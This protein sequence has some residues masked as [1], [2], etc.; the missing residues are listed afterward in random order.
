[1]RSPALIY[2]LLVAFAVP[3][4]S[5][6]KNAPGLQLPIKRAKGVIV[7]DGKIDEPDWQE[8]TAA[9]DFFLNYPVDTAAAPFQTEARLTFDE[10]ALYVSFVCYDD[11]TPDIVQ[12]LRRDF[13]F[14]S[15][16]NIGIYLG[17]YNDGINGFF[18]QTTPFGVQTEGIISAAGADDNSYNSTWDNKWY[19]KTIR[20][21]DKW[22][23]ELMIP[24]KS[25]RYKNGIDEWNIT[26]LRYDL[27]RNHTSSWIATP[28]QFIPASFAYS[29]KLL[30]EEPPPKQSINV[31]LIP[32][33]AGGLSTDSE[34]KPVTRTSDLQ[35]GFDA[36]IGVTPS[37]NL[38]LTVNPDFSQV[39]VDRQVINLTRFEFQFPERRQ[40]F[41]ENNDLFER[42][43]F[44]DARPFFSRRIGLVR[45]TAQ[46]LRRVPIAYGARLSGSLSKKWRLSVLNM[47]T[48][49][50]LELGLPAQ[51]FTVAAVQRN[52]WKQ[53]NLQFS[54]VNKQSLGISFGDSTKY[55]NSSLYKFKTFGDG[56]KVLND[57]NRVATVDLETRSENNTWYASLYYSRSFDNWNKDNTQTG[58]GFLSYTKRNYQFFLGQTII[59]KNYTAEAG[60]VP[61]RGVYP[62]V[63]N[64]FVNVTGTIYPKSK[65]LVNMVPGVGV[66]LSH[67]PGGTLTDKA[68]SFNYNFNLQNTSRII[69]LHNQIFQRLTNTFN[70]IN[71]EKFTNYFAGDEYNWSNYAVTYQS[72]QRNVFRYQLGVTSGSFYNGENL[73]LNGEINYRYQPYGSVSVRFDYNDLKLPENYG[74]EKLFVVSPRFDLT[75]TDKIFLTTFVQYNTLLDN[76]NLNARFQW[77]Y[78]PA[79]DF[80]LVYTENYLPANLA[81][82]NRA[83]VFKFTYWLNI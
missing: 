47:Q 43:G 48:K 34:T 36:K 12:S 6:Q 10:H 63:T 14:S 49:E 35:A 74:K 72:D 15:N 64:T 22:I 78:K 65:W 83:I 62:G 8:A 29:G 30:W 26:F 17:P 7:L 4:F 80:F 11:K 19:S 5:Q 75:F 79:S 56:R 45:D 40:F 60:F 44:P 18:F 28:I 42:M 81:S 59:E 33:V 51:D 39:E 38:D 73:N 9:K 37:L 46:V 2:V 50:K 69:L 16:D 27:K 24:F 67:I 3:V 13:D 68:I 25:F 20:Y 52:F 76:M 32:Y 58:G 61:S 55:F 21:E 71:G 54:F 82:K 57:F 23:A 31:S 70:P 66:Q 53:S 1:M 41:L 77:R